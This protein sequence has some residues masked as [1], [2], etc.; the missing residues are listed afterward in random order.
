VVDTSLDACQQ[1]FA[2]NI[3]AFEG[4]GLDL[5]VLTE[6]GLD[7]VGTFIALTANSD[8]NLVIAQRVE[9]EFHPAKVYGIYHK[10]ELLSKEIMGKDIQQAFGSQV[11]VKSWCESIDRGAAILTESA[12]E[13]EMELSQLNL[14]HQNGELLP[15]LLERSQQLQIVAANSVWQIGDRLIYLLEKVSTVKT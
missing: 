9:E 8:L 1:A 7:S 15:L 6:A 13:T 12:I 2:D 5:K 10:N 11:A 3:P 14:L 4:N